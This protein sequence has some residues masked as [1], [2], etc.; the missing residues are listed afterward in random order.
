MI[1]SIRF[2]RRVSTLSIS[3]ALLAL[4]MASTASVG[5]SAG[6]GFAGLTPR[7]KG[8]IQTH[9][10]VGYVPPVGW[11]VQPGPEGITVLSGLVPDNERPCEVWMLPP[12]PFQGELANEGVALVEC[13]A[14]TKQSGP[15]RDDS[16]RDARLSCVD[17]I[18]GMGQTYEVHTGEVV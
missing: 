11:R 10:T 12:I 14:L 4:V 7:P 16:G 17:R 1:A 5:Q 6:D 3:A 2:M 15:D 8:P 9:G 18:T 13:L